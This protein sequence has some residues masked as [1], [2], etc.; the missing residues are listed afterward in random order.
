M[1]SKD[2]RWLVFRLKGSLLAVPSFDLAVFPFQIH[3]LVFPNHGNGK[4][5][6]C[7]MIQGR[8]TC[9]HP[10]GV[11]AGGHGKDG[12]AHPAFDHMVHHLIVGSSVG[13][14]VLFQKFALPLFEGIF[15]AWIKM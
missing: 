11:P 14:G 15:L 5:V 7:E 12:L 9:I 13:S 2:D 10:S 3:P 8:L 1:G 6:M 4:T